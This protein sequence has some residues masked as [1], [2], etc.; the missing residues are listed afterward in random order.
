MKR[1]RF[2]QNLLV[3]P[4]APAAIAAVQ[5]TKPQQQPT[6]Q[7]NTPARQ[8]PRQPQEVAKLELVQA[9]LAAATEQRFFT[10]EQFTALQKLGSILMPPL[11]GK[12]GATDAGAAE[13]LDFLLSVSPQDRQH[14]YKN[15]L[16]NLNQEARRQF[17]KPFSELA[18][19][20]ADAIL[21]PLLVVRYWP[22]DLPSDPL[23]NFVTQV[24]EDLRTATTNSREWSLA[25][26]AAHSGR[27]Q[28]SHSVGLYW[29][30]IDPVIRD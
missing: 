25:S 29:N 12:P 4:I 1:R 24:H 17:Q 30:P 26:A 9:D 11:K 23:K 18:A 5:E 3:A 28:R 15:G 13:F 6:P 20:Q 10:A 16:D 7:P 2:V 14:L 22:E 19:T 8:V 27:R 21:R